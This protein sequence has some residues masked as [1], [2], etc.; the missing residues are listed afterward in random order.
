MGTRVTDNDTTTLHWTSPSNARTIEF[1]QLLARLTHAGDVIAMNG[2]LGAGKT[3][4]VRGIATGLGADERLVSSP[5]FVLM[6]E[7]PGK[8]P[9][10]HVD[11]YRMQGLSDLESLGWSDELLGEAVTLI[12]WADRIA[13]DLPDDRLEIAIG[14]TGEE[15][16]TL[17]IEPHGSWQNRTELIARAIEQVSPTRPCPTCQ[18]PVKETVKS[19]PFCSERCRL[20]DLG[21]WFDEKYRISRP[22][23]QR[24]IEA[25][26]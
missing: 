11:A 21:G 25:Q 12:E 9:I 22:I 4:L 13:D 15:Q 10:V 1:G 26:D 2:P 5:T 24:D 17:S 6:C 7:Y 3:Q 20:A 16:R 8:L 19:F 18:N 14:H 23:E